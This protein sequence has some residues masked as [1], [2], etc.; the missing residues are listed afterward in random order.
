MAMY[1]ILHSPLV[2]KRMTQNDKKFTIELFLFCDVHLRTSSSDTEKVQILILAKRVR[3]YF[4]ATLLF[5]LM[6]CI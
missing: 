2:G 3:G 4:A 6:R 1:L 5:L